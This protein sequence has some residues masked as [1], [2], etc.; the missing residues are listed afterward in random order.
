MRALADDRYLGRI[1]AHKRVLDEALLLLPPAGGDKPV[2][3]GGSVVSAAMT[4][5][6]PPSPSHGTLR[7]L[8]PVV[9][10]PHPFVA[11]PTKVPARVAPQGSVP[12]QTAPPVALDP[13]D[14]QA[15]LDLPGWGY[16]GGGYDGPG[17]RARILQLL[18]KAEA[19]ASPPP[20]PGNSMREAEVI[21]DELAKAKEFLRCN[22]RDPYM[23][24]VFQGEVAKLEQEQA[25]REAADEAR[26]A[27]AGRRRAVDDL[28]ALLAEEAKRAG[29][30]CTC[31]D[32]FKGFRERWA[33]YDT[34]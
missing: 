6:A 17:K 34:M 26:S 8:I 20:A 18:E 33:M 21:T 4:T 22:E 2:A 16:S 10:Q 29:N 12:P 11:Q 31:A 1:K 5:V 7:P 27:S 25:D 30:D 32:L 9:A 24:R 19:P 23:S 15:V 14:F 3:G 13:A 28:R